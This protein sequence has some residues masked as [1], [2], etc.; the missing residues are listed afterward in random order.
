[1]N[2]PPSLSNTLP[3]TS[4]LLYRWC[5]HPHWVEKLICK[6]SS[7]FSILWLLHKAS[8]APVSASVFLFFWLDWVFVAMHRLSVFQHQF[9]SWLCKPEQKKEA[10][11]GSQ[12]GL[13]VVQSLSRVQLFATPWTTACQASSSSTN[14]QN[15]LKL[16]SIES[17]M[18]S[19]HL[20]LCCPL[21]PPSIFPSIRVFS[22]ESVL[23]IR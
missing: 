1:M 16:M 14:S 21:L 23:C 11:S 22:N 15:L 8:A 20:I 17:L 12:L 5:L 10:D 18:P 9:L 13:V 7:C 4:T 6:L 3:F 2:I 19:N